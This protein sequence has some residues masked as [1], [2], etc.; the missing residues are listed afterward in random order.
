MKLLLL[1][2]FFGFNL[3]NNVIIAMFTAN[4]FCVLNSLLIN[5]KECLSDII[6]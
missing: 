1:A 4:I 3:I 6:F 5:I 2:I